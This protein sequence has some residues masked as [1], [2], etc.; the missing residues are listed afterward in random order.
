MCGRAR[1][2]RFAIW[3]SR[4]A[5]FAATLFAAAPALT[6]D[7]RTHRLITRLA[8]TALPPS[9]LTDF[10]SRNEARLEYFAVEP[11][12]IRGRT[13]KVRHYIDLE[14]YGTDPI[15]KL[16]PDEAAMERKWGALTLSESGSLPWT[17]KSRANELGEAWRRSDCAEVLRLSGYLA[18]YIGDASQPLHTTKYFEG[19]P[20]YP[21][22]RNLHERLE[23]AAD[24][25]AV[26]LAE[27]ARPQVKLQPVTSVWEAEIGEIRDAHSL[28]KTVI[29]T[30][31]AARASAP[32]HTSQ[33]DAALLA[34]ERSLIASQVAR[35]ASVL[36]SV[37]LFE[38]EQAGRP[39]AC[40]AAAGR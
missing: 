29:Y 3:V 4:A 7:Q 40:A 15:S 10:F 19:Y 22:D 24:R 12:R 5:L 36:G 2:R 14:L 26:N 18:H 13:E 35:A 17:I 16:D 11:D 1:R 34:R 33:F 20:W 32:I 27:L 31:R 25:D 37:W 38:W 21:G 30:D 39:A 28:V 6:W 23:R 8:V 9:P